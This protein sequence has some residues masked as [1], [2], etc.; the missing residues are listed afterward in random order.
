[1]LIGFTGTPLLKDDKKTSLEVFGSYI[2]TYK[3]DQA[4]RDG[5]ILDLLY[6]ARDVDQV[7]TSQEK[8][9]RWFEAKTQGLSPLGLAQLKQRW[10]TMQ[11]VL[12]AKSRLEQALE[13]AH[14]L[15]KIVELTRQ[16][17]NPAQGPS[18]LSALN[19]PA[20]RAFYDN[21]GNDEQLAVA[22]DT[23]IH[24]T[25]KDGWRGDVVKEREIKYAVYQIVGN[26]PEA[27]ERIFELIQNQREY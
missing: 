8:I 26:D 16:V 14:Y 5:V 17:K 9:D 23:A 11:R 3:F 22:L 10:G 12:S 7:L 18:Y 21:L 4:V 2:H 6:E 24:A 20:R 13:Y 15:A 19:T 25:K 27:I 1:M